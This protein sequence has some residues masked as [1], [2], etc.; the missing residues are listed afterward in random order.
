MKKNIKIV[1]ATLIFTS[2]CFGQTGT[3]QNQISLRTQTDSLNYTLGLANGDGI[4]NYYLKDKPLEEYIS[5]FMKSLDAAYTSDNKFMKPDSTN[6][7]ASIIELANKVGTALKAQASTGLMGN[8]SLKI[9]F[10]LIKKGLDDGLRNNNSLMTP[11]S[12]QRYL[13]ATMTKISKK[14]LSPEDK[15]NKTAGEEYLTKNKLRKEVITT[16]SGL[17]YEILKKGDGVIPKATDNVKVLYVGSKIDGTVFDDKT[18][19]EQALTSKLSNTIKGWIEA[20]QIMQVGSKFKIYVPQE[21]AYGAMKQGDIKPYSTLI[22]EI[23]L[24]SIEK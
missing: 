11:E 8:P 12:A 24:L 16:K 6:K 1:I 20:L 23:E 14:N 21:L 17:Q 19:P 10:Q 9:D 7:Y 22:F 2:I 5:V 3:A 18:Q 4:R 13:Q 15:L